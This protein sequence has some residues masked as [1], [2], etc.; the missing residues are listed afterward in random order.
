MG[1]Q[2]V[3]PG[4]LA[5]ELPELSLEPLDHLPLLEHDLAQVGHLAFEV[6]VSDLEVDEPLLHGAKRAIAR[7]SGRLRKGPFRTEMRIPLRDSAQTGTARRSLV[8]R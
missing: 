3:V 7:C 5:T 2:V 1:R 4:K 8:E 6:R